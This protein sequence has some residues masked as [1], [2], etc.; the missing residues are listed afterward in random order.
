MFK[1]IKE[2]NVLNKRVL[3]R[4]DFNVPL[5]GSGNILDDF[6]IKESVLTIKYLIENKA[7]VILMSHLGD[8]EG[9][10]NPILKLDKIGE[11]LGDILKTEIMKAD[12][13]V[14]PA[15]E[16]YT[17]DLRGGEVLLL[18][19]LRF[20]QEE[21]AGSLE[22]AEKI[23]WLGDIYINDAFSVCHRAHASITGLPQYLPSYAGFLLLKEIEN[24]DKV[25]RG[26]QGP[27][28][29]IVGGKKIE[30]KS[31]FINKI[32]ELADFVLISGLIKK[33]IQDK[34]IQLLRLE[35]IMGPEDFLDAKDI[36][37]KAIDMFC[38]KILQAKTIVWNGPF[39]KYED[40]KYA[41]GTLE[42]AKAIIESRAFSVVGGGETIEFLKKQ[43][44]ID[45]FSHISS[46]GGAMLSYLAGEK[47]P[48]LEALM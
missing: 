11:R 24:L 15:I 17:Q 14:G 19:N 28:V 32:S 8:P 5:D 40:D 30:T 9:K 7:K 45:K 18:E 31:K 47:M 2:L 21:K 6:R 37:Q 43:G 44:I 4:C 27:V 48:G 20:H 29:V 23:S 42:I 10:I 41:K 3:V 36:N 39:G 26:G 34:G 46:G 22:F 16:S 13:C 35:K 12:D 38:E 25:L 33:E 1:S